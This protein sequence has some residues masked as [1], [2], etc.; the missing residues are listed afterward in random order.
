MPVDYKIFI[1]PLKEA[2][3][4]AKPRN[5]KQSFELII[6]LRDVD[7][8]R[9]ENRVNMPVALPHPP[10]EKMAKVCVIAA[11]DLYVKAK[12]AGADGV[13]SREDL[14]KIASDKKSAKKF[15]KSYDFF[16]AQADMM[17]LIGR[18]LGRYLGPA[19]KMPRPVPPT[20]DIA[21]LVDSLKR[22]VRIRIRTQ[23]LVMC[24]VGLEDQ[25]LEEVAKNIAAVFS[26]LETK[27]RI[28]HNIEKVYVKLTMGPAV[29]VRL[30]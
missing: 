24:R 18:L 28:P 23:P 16:I 4:K 25:P 29:K 20:A 22:S 1:N 21:L 8:K 11:G 30:K 26:A 3:E 15:V 17:P 9:P 27:F 19:G 13:I 12:S 2:K 7:L 6:K 5:F 10:K 14:E